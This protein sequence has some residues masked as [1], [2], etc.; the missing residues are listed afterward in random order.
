MFWVYWKEF[1]SHLL[2]E[3]Q[4]PNAISAEDSTAPLPTFMDQSWCLWHP[5]EG[6]VHFSDNWQQVC[7]L[8]AQQCVKGQL[9]EAIHPEDHAVF[10]R[11]LEALVTSQ[12]REANKDSGTLECRIVQP[13]GEARWYECVFR[14]S[15]MQSKD[16]HPLVV[17]AFRDIQRL[18]ELKQKAS[19]ATQDSA[20]AEKGR[21]DFLTH[22]SHELRTPLNAI[23]GFTQIIQ[24]EAYGSLGNPSYGEYIGHIRHSGE[25]L[26]NKINNL[27]ELGNINTGE[28]EGQD[29]PLNLK[30]V[31]DE[32]VQMHSHR[33]FERD[34]RLRVKEPVPCIVLQGN[35]VR[36]IQAVA[37]LVENA[38]RYSSANQEVCISISEKTDELRIVIEDT[39]EGIGRAQL[40]HMREALEHEQGDHNPLEKGIGVG[41]LLANRIAHTHDGYLRIENRATGGCEACFTLPTSRILSRSVRVKAKQ[42][43][44]IAS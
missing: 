40:S 27:L 35:R 26:L 23:L 31:I 11:R 22:M 33:A 29:A 15:N 32:V 30:D 7:G 4:D 5:L 38:L 44:A 43:S 13:N 2:E 9:F 19:L 3:E 16:S 24:S 39:G 14:F 25:E 8:D 1:Y 41:L 10:F 28:E 42:R 18:V 36:I 6:C 12:S 37:N 17:F 21:R 34:I 20:Y